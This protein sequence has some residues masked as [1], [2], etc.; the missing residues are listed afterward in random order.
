MT[1]IELERLKCWAQRRN[2]DRSDLSE[3]VHLFHA[4]CPWC[5]RTDDPAHEGGGAHSL[6]LA[7]IEEV[8]RLRAIVAALVES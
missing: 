7:L 4:F 3:Q 5:S 6:G 1:D 8:Q 2:P